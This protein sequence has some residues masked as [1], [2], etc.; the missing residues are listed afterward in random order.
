MICA[1]CDRPI[2]PDEDYRTAMNFG[3]SGAG[4]DIYLHEPPCERPPEVQRPRT[5]PRRTRHGR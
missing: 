1:R 5:Y 3:A 4:A 2:R